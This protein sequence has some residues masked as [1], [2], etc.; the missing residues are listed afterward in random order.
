MA[1]PADPTP[2]PV[3]VC[4]GKACRRRA[5]FADLRSELMGVPHVETRCL[6]VCKGPVV[7]VGLDSGDELVLAMVRSR[8]QRR[9][10]AAN[11]RQRPG[12]QRAARAA[13]G[14]RIEAADRP[15]APA[16]IGTP[17]PLSAGIHRGGDRI[18]EACGP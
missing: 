5:E 11:D 18:C 4:I 17:P 16:P 8:K 12:G 9:D 10:L 3:V 7:V 6:D 2:A 14:H 13:L 1:H 15:P